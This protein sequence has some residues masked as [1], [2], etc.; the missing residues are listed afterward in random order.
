MKYVF[1]PVP[2]RR[3]GQSLGIDPLPA[4]TCNL[5]C[6]YCQLGRT[7]PVTNERRDFY[8]IAEM[9][10][11]VQTALNQHAPGDIDWITVAASGEPTLHTGLGHLIFKL[12]RMTSIPIAVLTN[13]VLLHLPAVRR[14]LKLA[15]AVLPSL[16]VGTPA[17]FKKLN[18]PHGDVTFE[19]LVDGLITFRDEYRG[20]LW[21]EVMLVQGLNDSELALKEIAAIL[22]QIRP[23]EVHINVP[24]RPPAES[25]V[26]PPDA[27]GLMRAT[28]VFGQIA[29]V[30]HP[31][32]G[33]FDLSGC[34]SVM[35]AVASIIERHP[36]RQEELEQALAQWAPGQVADALSRLKSTGRAQMI[37][38]LGKQFWTAPDAHFP[39]EPPADKKTNVPI[40]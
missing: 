14:D 20:R 13:G 9:L 39:I 36:M 38:R 11:E 3:L 29:H 17:L 26:A 1:G 34:G 2:S 6:V 8:P 22:A 21:V 25:W 10:A 24:T 31:A 12:R 28:A 15:H 7:Q 16:D 35:E 37:E 32:A 18:R 19:Q 23:D 40:L 30:I 33:S 5:N 27:E 4:K